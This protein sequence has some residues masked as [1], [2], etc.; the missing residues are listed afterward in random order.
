MLENDRT[1]DLRKKADSNP[2][3]FLILS[4]EELF[5]LLSHSA[6]PQEQETI[7]IILGLKQQKELVEETKKLAKS[8]RWVAFATWFL[9]V[10]TVLA[11]IFGQ[12]LKNW[13]LGP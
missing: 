11:T 10:A 9:V 6:Y 8:T 7:K 3:G 4:M 12:D 13:L 1:T 5:Y 2:L